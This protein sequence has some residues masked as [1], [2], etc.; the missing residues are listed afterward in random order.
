[1]SNTVIIDTNDTPDKGDQ[2]KTFL[3]N[4][5]ASSSLWGLFRQ[6]YGRH[7]GQGMAEYAILGALILLVAIPVVGRG[8]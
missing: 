1:M 7:C 6:R 8:R 2:S 3:R 4:P 5:L